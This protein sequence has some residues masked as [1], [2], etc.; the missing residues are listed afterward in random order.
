MPAECS[1][2]LQ[3]SPELE[4]MFEQAKQD[5]AEAEDILV[6]TERLVRTAKFLFI[7]S[8]IFCIS[9]VISILV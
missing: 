4:T 6:S 9:G 7:F 5:R 8:A 2:K 3:M 1:F